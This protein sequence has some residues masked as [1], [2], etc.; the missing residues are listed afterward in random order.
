MNGA[1]VYE[2]STYLFFALAIISSIYGSYAL[3]YAYVKK[4]DERENYI[5]LKS[6]TQSFFIA[7]ILF[8][9]YYIIQISVNVADI[10]INKIMEY[11]S[12]RRICFQLVQLY[13]G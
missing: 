11:S 12:L 2:I 10:T 8:F 7:I 4:K 1:I 13:R 6:A 5:V 9:V 3:Y